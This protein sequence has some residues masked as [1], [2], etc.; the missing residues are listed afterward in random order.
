MTR[1][2]LVDQDVLGQPIDPPLSGAVIGSDAPLPK[3]YDGF[4]VPRA[5][6]SRSGGASLSAR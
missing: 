2:L 3:F 4:E 5:T 6:R 1:D